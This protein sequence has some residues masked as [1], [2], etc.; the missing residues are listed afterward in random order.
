MPSSKCGGKRVALTVTTLSSLP[1]MASVGLA[2][3]QS[4]T[5]G[6]QASGDLAEI[7]VTAEK[8]EST[9]QKTPISITAFSGDALE[10]QGTTG[11]LQVAQ[12]TPGV[13]FRTAGPG[14]TEFEVRGLASSGGATATVG[15]YFDDVPISTPAVG[16][17]GKIAID[18]N[19]YDINRVEVLRGP[20]GTLY[21][22]GSMGG[23]I[24]IITN[25][26]KLNT[27]ESSVDT[28]VSWTESNGGTNWAGN[29]M[30][31]VPIVPDRVALRVVASSITTSGWID[32]IVVN[33]FPVP[34]NNGCT[35]TFFL[36]CARGNVAAGPFQQVIP[37][38]NWSQL[39][40][41]RSNLL[42]QPTDA[43][44]I[45]TSAMYQRT[46]AGGYS[47]F[48]SPPGTDG[49]LA[50]YQPVNIPE[51][52]E[53][54][55][56]LVGLDV[57]YDFTGVQLTSASSYWS[58]SL[59][60]FQDASEVSE[61]IYALP[62]F[63]NVGTLEEDNT[64]Q[65]AQ[66]VRLSSTGSDPF[67]WLVGGFYSSLQYEW[68]Q[69]QIDPALTNYVYG[70]GLYLPVTAAQNPQGILYLGHVPYDMKQEAGFTDLSYQF[71]SA[72]K[73]SAG[74][75][76]YSYHSVENTTQSGIFSQNVS[77][78]P[79]LG[80]TEISS[81]GVNP[82]ENLSYTPNDDLTLYETIAKGFRPGGL[83]LL[84]PSAGPN[85]CSAA[86]EAIGQNTT[87]N[88]T[89]QSDSVWSYEIGEKARLADQRI[90]INSAVYYIRWNNIQ[91]LVPLAC[92]AFTTVNAGDARSYGAESEI[93]ANIDSNWS[94]SATGGYTNAEI[95]DPNPA[96]GL[97][98][99]TPILNIPKYT[100][101]GSVQYSQPLPNNWNL[102]ARAAET[103]VGSSTDEAFTY[104]RLPSYALL[105]AR[106]GLLADRWNLYVTGTNLT[107]KVAELTA[108]NTSLSSNS[109]SLTRFTTNQPRTIGLNVSAK[110]GGEH[111]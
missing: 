57:T 38:S 13:S 1:F 23:T 11:M 100:G 27:F 83:N 34:T 65:F 6:S 109:P 101:S 78:V 20:Q 50:H 64:G 111:Q 95:N 96:V 69:S 89:Y 106:I 29:A 82:K 92:G 45:T 36:G 98:A 42:I 66:E 37:Q 39:D 86:L 22:S 79:T 35:P 18:P 58:R 103:Y 102:T 60:Q 104:V 12:E 62:F 41:V 17:I 52:L 70:T 19:L 25:Q 10:A 3:Q 49:P 55:V 87:S 63:P 97:P 84:L 56:R 30:L 48:D 68:I 43:L 71:T 40:T 94:V 90:T 77:A 33:P 88:N 76:Y 24:K 80:H 15:Y 81:S 108:N 91:Q 61:N 51:P 7:V 26:P 105:D 5:T 99:G 44:K 107:N 28:N 93:H 75:R 53:D 73:L 59:S 9:V 14:Q 4:P 2:Q 54:Y 8:R 72:W 16:D 47:N 32:R 31:N 74:A 67:Q 46:I 21:G 110:F 85:S